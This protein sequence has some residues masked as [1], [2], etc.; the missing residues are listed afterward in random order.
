M[1]E[2]LNDVYDAESRTGEDGH[3]ID[4]DPALDDEASIEVL[5]CLF[6]SQDIG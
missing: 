4:D 5:G 6:D 2:D 3:V 1:S